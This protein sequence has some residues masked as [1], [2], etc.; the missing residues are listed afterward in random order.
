M[1][2]QG[3]LGLRD[4]HLLNVEN[5]ALLVYAPR[6]SCPLG[7]FIFMTLCYVYNHIPAS[8]F[9]LLLTLVYISS[10]KTSFRH[11]EASK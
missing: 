8:P 4:H 2:V 10:S 7:Y 5:L 11:V 3:T 1:I 9:K 6:R